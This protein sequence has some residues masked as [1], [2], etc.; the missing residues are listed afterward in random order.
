[1]TTNYI[2]HER[3]VF[4]TICVVLATLFTAIQ[5]PDIELVLGLTGSTIGTVIYILFPVSMFIKLVSHNTTEKLVAQAIFVVGV[6]ILVLG[7]YVTLYEADTK[8]DVETV[9][10]QNV[11]AAPH[12]VA[13]NNGKLVD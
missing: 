5:I 7:T 2:P 8:R 6:I 4:I 12:P 1:M 13:V 10:A 9:T 3:F 11:F